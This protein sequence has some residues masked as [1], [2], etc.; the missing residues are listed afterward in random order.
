[1]PSAPRDAYDIA[2]ILAEMRQ[3]YWESLETVPE[4]D[5]TEYDDYVV[6]LLGDERF[7]LPT[8]V[9]REVLRLPRLVRLPHVSEEI[10]GI[11]N[12]RGQI[13]AVSDLRPLF[14][15]PRD[16]ES[17][18][19]RLIVVA[20]GELLTALYCDRVEGIESHPRTAIENVTEGLANFPRETLRGQIM[21]ERGLLLLVDIEQVLARDTYF[22]DH[23]G[24]EE[25]T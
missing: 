23:K 19:G 5:E 6:F 10:L 9:T 2:T 1:M 12:L 16:E 13:L 17:H 11:I 22:V 7:A 15:L 21:S 3:E 14:Q 20:S 25:L 24:E 18:S 8:G 4:E